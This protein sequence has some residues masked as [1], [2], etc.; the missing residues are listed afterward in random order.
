M[1]DP[2]LGGGSAAPATPDVP[3]KDRILSV[4]MTEELHERLKAT[5]AARGWTVAMFVTNL[6]V[7]VTANP[8]GTVSW[9]APLSQLTAPA[10]HSGV[11]GEPEATPSKGS[12]IDSEPAPTPTPSPEGVEPAAAGWD[13]GIAVP[14][15]VVTRIA[16][17]A[18]DA[19]H[20]E[21][22]VC[23]ARAI[24]DRAAPLIAA[25]A[26][27]LGMTLLEHCGTLAPELATAFAE[28]VDALSGLADELERGGDR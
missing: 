3:T 21:H 23:W 5:A 1:K 27:R 26:L 13:G 17:D 24:V 6:L 8:N 28:A 10:I 11:A 4:R 12:E 14:D 19:V 25:Q 20:C 2:D 16:D 7:S 9:S 22:L 15:D 18:N